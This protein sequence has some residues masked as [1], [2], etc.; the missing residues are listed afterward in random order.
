MRRFA[1][2]AVLL[3]A[4]CSCAP[5]P[6]LVEPWTALKELPLPLPAGQAA[7]DA[8]I[9]VDGRGTV[10]ISWVTR[11]SMGADAW[12]AVS[13][14]SGEHWSKPQRLNDRAGKVSSYAESR[15][16]LAWGEGG[17]LLAAWAAA[18]DTGGYA[19]DIAVRASRDGGTSF[20]AVTLVNSDHTDPSSTYHGF[21]AITASAGGGAMLAWID[22]RAS[23]VSGE[24]PARAEIYAAR[25]SDGGASWGPDTSIAREVCPCCRIALATYKRGDGDDE[26]A[27]VYRGAAGDMRDPRLAISHDGGRTIALDTLVSAD[28]WKLP[29]CPSVG[30]VVSFGP[31]GSYVAWFTGESPEDD[32]LPGRP[33]PGVYLNAWQPSVGPLNARIAVN[34][35]V[36][37][38]THPL[39]ANMG[40]ATL[41]GVL[42]RAA[43]GPD[44]HVLAVRT[45][46]SNGS[47][48]PWLYLGSQVRS[49]ALATHGSS[50]AYA[51]WTEGERDAPRLRLMRLGRPE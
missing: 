11:D 31:N 13:A 14:D 44:R 3:T 32:S 50:R 6:S 15:P 26:V 48:T 46:E 47:R 25:S 38:A 51:L 23:A 2:I 40:P 24:E 8:S 27:L 17:N 9:A 30:P 36:R 35:S 4:V 33:A 39:L 42:A 1:I 34:D 12:V 28:R 7:T 16:V 45:L 5:R 20:G 10:A 22:G 29:G 19:D 21:M 49:A 41:I 18:R 37:E 43:S